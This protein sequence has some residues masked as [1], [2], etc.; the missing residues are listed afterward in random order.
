M[1]TQLKSLGQHV[2]LFFTFDGVPQAGSLTNVQ[3]FS[4]TPN[5][6]HLTI[7]TL[8][9]STPQFDMIDNGT[10][11]KFSILEE[12][13]TVA[14]NLFVPLVNKLKNGEAL[15][16]VNITKIVKYR[17]GTLPSNTQMFLSVNLKLDEWMAGSRTDFT[18]MTLSGKCRAVT[19]L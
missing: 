16:V 17:A 18:K 2:T 13:A 9:E 15:P 14:N 11:L 4:F 6:E 19:N 3:D 5:I 10:D 12:D 7:Q 1:S 8:G